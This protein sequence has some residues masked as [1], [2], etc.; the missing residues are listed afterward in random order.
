MENWTDPIAFPAYCP[1]PT[2]PCLLPPASKSWFVNRLLACP[3]AAEC[4]KKAFHHPAA[5]SFPALD[6]VTYPPNDY[7]MSALTKEL[8]EK[9]FGLSA[10]DRVSL[11]EKLLSSLDTPH[12]ISI[13]EKWAAESEDRIK[14]YDAGLIESVEAAT[15][16]ERLEGKYIQ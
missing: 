9:V 5:L 6:K 13:D 7:F 15:V 16:F 3:Y 11:A 8:E 14:A 2:A 12:Q 10:L 4:D 1:L